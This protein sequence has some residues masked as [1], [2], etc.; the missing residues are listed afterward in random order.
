MFMV[1][2]QEMRE[3]FIIRHPQ[4][5]DGELIYSL[6]TNS[7]PLEINSIYSYLLICSHFDQTSAVC[8]FEGDIVG[9]TSAYI[10]PHKNDTLFIWQIAVQENM[11]DRGIAKEMILRILQ[12]KNLKNIKYIETTV[13]PNNKSSKSMFNRLA[14]QLDAPFNE[15]SYF[16]R[17]VFGKFDHPE[18]FIIR[19]GPF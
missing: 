10:H 8:E 7:P 9:F 18:E 19:I 12:R 11:R 14:Q 1:Q 13:T 3:S 6:S 4:L 5:N 2:K 15:E 16:T 17:E